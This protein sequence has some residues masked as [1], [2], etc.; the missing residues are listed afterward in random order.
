[1]KHAQRVKPVKADNSNKV[2]PLSAE[3]QVAEK[4]DRAT[5]AAAKSVPFAMP[6]PA[7]GRDLSERWV[8]FLDTLRQRSENMLEHE[9]QG[10]PP[11]LDFKYETILDARKLRLA[12]HHRSRG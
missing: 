6:S 8:L 2:V 10:M 5:P 3:I 9:R 7:Y 11:L 4:P 1:M 12:A